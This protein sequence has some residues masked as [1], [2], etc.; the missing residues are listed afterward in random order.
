[1]DNAV[2]Q[3]IKKT[4]F[5]ILGM[6]A[7]L[8]T[9]VAYI[10][11]I[12][13]EELSAHR[14][15]QRA[16]QLER[17]IE[18]GAILDRTGEKLAYSELQSDGKW[19]R[20]Y[21]FGAIT[22]HVIGYISER[23]GSAGIEEIQNP[24]LSGIVNPVRRLGILARLVPETAGT[25]VQLTLD[26]EVQTIAYRALGQHR[27]AVVVLDPRTGAVLAMVSRPGFDP[28]AIDRNWNSISGSTAS[29]LMN[30]ATYG[31]YPPGS[32]IKILVAEAALS[33]KAA[34]TNKIYHC[35]GKL[36]IGQDYVL[37]EA[38]NHKHG[39]INLEQA[40]AVSC[41]VTFGRLALDLGRDKLAQAYTK[42]GFTRS[43]NSDFPNQPA[44]L[45]DFSRL[46]DGDL[47]QLGIGQGTLLV[48]PLHMAMLAAA[49]ANKGVMMQ[50]YLV[51]GIT[52]KDGLLTKKFTPVQLS[53]PVKPGLAQTIGG[54][55]VTTV[56]AGTGSAASIS[57]ITVAGKT[58]TAENPHGA[59][60]SWFIG[61]AS[62]GESQVAIAVIVENGGSGGAVAA[63]IA[64]QVLVQALR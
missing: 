45:P 63:P 37:G 9:Y 13:G 12:S 30:R 7:I 55:M 51:Q 15:N 50:P 10:Q 35:D 52:T 20:Q 29:P 4:A 58:G 48:T 53:N 33:E 36:R 60:H 56:K 47:A 32:I 11:I 28:A 57:G 26:S 44:Q 24:A 49:F 6:L 8:L 1:M 31:L 21:P 39:A 14:L 25:N 22:A 16:M 2:N 41:N 42:Y 43:T 64:R 27:G 3:A 23:Y 5:V 18:R 46:S 40:L 54:M 19:Q 38:N 59:D 34:D 17:R 62:A 61:F